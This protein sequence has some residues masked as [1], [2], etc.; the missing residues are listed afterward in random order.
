LWCV[1]LEKGG[2]EEEVQ[3]LMHDIDQTFEVLNKEKNKLGELR[4]ELL[5]QHIE[6]IRM[7]FLGAINK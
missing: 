1:V 7:K 4:R 6:R 3:S 2:W 5:M